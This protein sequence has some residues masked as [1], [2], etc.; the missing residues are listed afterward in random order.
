MK[1]FVNFEFFIDRGG[2]FTDVYAKWHDGIDSYFQVLKLLSEDPN[3]YP[4]APREAI[5]RVLSTILGGDRFLDPRELLAASAADFRIDSI[6][7]GTTVAT[8][9]LLERKGAKFALVINKGFGDLLEIGYQNRPKIFELDIKKP[10]LLY[11]EVL[12]LD[13]RLI[14]R[15]DALSLEKDI[16]EASLEK[17][18]KAIFAK[19]IKNLAVVLMYSYLDSSYEERIADL[20]YRLGF[21][22]VSLSS[23]V[24]PMIKMVS[25]GETTL[26]D[27]YLSPIIKNYIENFKSGFK[28]GL[29]DTELLFMKSDAGLVQ[30][31][32]FRGYNSILSGPAGG[33]VGYA[34]LMQLGKG[35]KVNGEFEH[36]FY[37]SP[38]TFYPIIGFDM[39]GTSTDVSR[40]DGDYALSFES[41]IDGLKIQAP[42][43]DIK[44][45]AAGGGSRLF[46]ENGMFRVGPESA[47]SDPG[48]VCYKKN[49]YLAITDANLIL[50]R[51]VPELFPKVFGKN[52]DEGLDV[53]ASKK[54]F[55]ELA[56]KIN[57]YQEL[58]DLKKL[59]IEEIAQGFIDLANEEMA[60]PIR[61]ISVMRGFDIKNHILACFGG[62]GA[63]HACALARDLG[64]TKIIIH[65]YSGILSAYG[66]GLAKEV[67]EKQ[68]AL[69]KDLRSFMSLEEE[70][71]S[72]KNEIEINER[73]YLLK[74]FLNLRYQGTDTAFMIEEPDDKDYGKEFKENYLREFGFD[75]ENR[76][77]I[78]D[79]I[80]IRIEF[81]G[82]ITTEPLQAIASQST[83]AITEFK[84]V[85]FNS[86]LYKTPV[87]KFS[88]LS[89]ETI[90]GP[91]LI[92]Q[93][94]AT[95]VLE[96]DTEAHLDNH[97]NLK[98]TIL[99]KD[100]SLKL[101]NETIQLSIFANRFMSIAEQM[102]RT[103]EKTAIS[104]NI[105]ER[106]DFSCA[107]FDREGNL[108]ANAPHQPVHLGSM[109]HAV[110]S[111]IGNFNP[112]TTVLSNHP[113]MG[114]SH[115][116]DLTVITPV[117]QGRIE[118]NNLKPTLYVA[119]RGHHADIGGSTPGSM[120]SFS[121]KLS[122]EGIAIEFFE[123]VKDGKFQ[124][125]ELR[126]LFKESRKIEDN[127]SDLKAQVAANRKGI[128]LIDDL[129][130]SYSL[131][132]VEKNMLG[133]Q[134][135]AELAVRDLLRHCEAPRS[136]NVAIQSSLIITAEDFLDDG[137]I[138]KLKII[139][140]KENG[141]A[142]FDFTGTAAELKNS[143]LN[144]PIAVTSSA[145]LYTLRCML[146]K[147]IPLNQGCLKPI[148]IIIP[149]GS[150]LNPSETAAVVGGNVQT[151]QRIVDVIF[152]AF[153]YVAA[154]QGCMN[155]ISFGR[156]ARHCEERSDV[157]I[158]SSSNL[159]RDAIARD[160]SFGYYETVGGGA[161]AGKNFHGASAVHTHMTNTRITD[162]EILET[163]YP[164]ILREFSIRKGSGGKGKFN[165]GDGIVRIFEFLDDLTLS[166]LTERRNYAPYG[167]EGGEAGAK[168][169]NWLIRDD[170]KIRLEAKAELEVHK[171]DK[172]MILTPGGG[173]YGS[174]EI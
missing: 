135:A 2:T 113:K 8:N 134:D 108:V 24:S 44:T 36:S 71:N 29:A 74:K 31:E 56:L 98:I 137:S 67:I 127:V 82:D 117:Y 59:S 50:G 131:E 166:I 102:G 42:Q 70:F 107:I 126:E 128:E 124:E 170:K 30:A 155:N 77:I 89:S 105:K 53:E 96:P 78:I 140:D 6:K 174:S 73:S 55:E 161:G 15:K 75:L 141:E 150:I 32:N 43:L 149:E 17:D 104:T 7:M 76:E 26:I 151:S 85:F 158:Q 120:P 91:A 165:G 106:R 46:F 103:L 23:D 114:G 4:D 39:G 157:A 111:Q 101:E 12:E 93:D 84:N 129:I 148:N 27:A 144:T 18:L 9:A 69:G 133:I 87:Y 79:D 160:D 10:E 138:I 48:P 22:H 66:I 49:G 57:A 171:N 3:N 51:L 156:N 173:G 41:E 21:E 40:F 132:T 20:A 154:S 99:E 13:H 115:L 94:T 153:N 167:L 81:E 45:V 47:G 5:R 172:L 143:N 60:R 164:V 37:P 121:R 64:M 34:S 109:G 19:G 136:G 168:G 68:K 146:D 125:T 90:P 145:I 14:P 63:Q 86:K 116:P 100:S 28:D 130:N 38:Y 169:E 72:L 33:V 65:K 159:D 152:K 11:K 25:R 122:E 123:L 52:A 147:E 83:L 163:R 1:Q 119:N 92:I 16:D 142:I 162:P 110:K 97:G 58:K 61:E 112:G 54:A 35:Y 88:D 95:I 62:A 139:I 80:R 118:D